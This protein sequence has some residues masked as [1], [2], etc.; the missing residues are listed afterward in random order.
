M[1]FNSAFKGLNMELGWLQSR[2]GVFGVDKNLLLLPVIETWLHF[3]P[4]LSELVYLPS[5]LF[6]LM[7]EMYKTAVICISCQYSSSKDYRHTSCAVLELS[8]TSV[9]TVGHHIIW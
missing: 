9:N 1:G 5:R 3:C 6:R 7:S 4:V 8:V 2:T